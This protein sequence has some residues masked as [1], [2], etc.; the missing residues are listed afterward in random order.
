[1]KRVING[2]RY[3]TDT[4]TRI[5]EY[6]YL[7]PSDFRYIDEALYI[8]RT[9]EYFLAGKGGAMSKYSKPCGDNSYS[10]GSDIFPLS[11]AMAREWVETHANDQYEEIFGPAPE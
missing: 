7:Y 9:G 3:D 6:S 1:M 5:A 4:A 10:G 2:K 8:K 11:D